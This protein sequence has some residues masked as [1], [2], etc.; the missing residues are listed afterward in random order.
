MLLVLKKRRRTSDWAFARRVEHQDSCHGGCS[1]Q[2][3]ALDTDRRASFRYYP[4]SGFDRGPAHDRRHGRQGIRCNALIALIT[5]TGAQA[6]IPPRRNRIEQRD[7]D[8]HLYKDRNLVER[9]FGRLKQFRRIAT[10]YEKLARN[11]LSM[12]NLACACIWLA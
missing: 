9:F 5:Q 8:R 3:T 11:F 7:Y 12:L 2:S 1:G 4:S 10:R 6:V